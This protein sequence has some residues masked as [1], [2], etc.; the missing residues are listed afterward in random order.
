MDKI[1]MTHLFFVIC[2]WES[3]MKFFINMHKFNWQLRN[4]YCSFLPILALFVCWV[5][6]GIWSEPR[7]RLRI[8]FTGYWSLWA[9][10]VARF[11]TS[12]NCLFWSLSFSF[13]FSFLTFTTNVSILSLTGI[14]CFLLLR[15][16]LWWT[17]KG[18]FYLSGEFLNIF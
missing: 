4:L 7:D 13:F 8:V 3:I 2:K 18:L 14:Y 1:S 6:Y 16:Y 12:Q 17:F 10:F 9:S 11:S 15:R 5:I